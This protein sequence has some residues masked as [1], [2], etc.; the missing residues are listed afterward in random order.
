MLSHRMSACSVI[1][2]PCYDT[3]PHEEAAQCQLCGTH[4]HNLV[5]YS[6][7]CVLTMRMMLSVQRH[8]FA[9]DRVLVWEDEPGA[10]RQA[11][12]PGPLPLHDLPK[13]DGIR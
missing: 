5:G 7:K 13:A 1:A 2:L 10:Q 8:G 3:M 11:A 9:D 6:W 4:Q 12:L